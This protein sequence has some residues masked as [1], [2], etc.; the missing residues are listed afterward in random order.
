MKK[1]RVVVKVGNEHFAKYRVN[2]LVKF[3]SF[4]DHTWPTWRWFNVYEHREGENGP[5][6]AN[7]TANNRP[8][9]RFV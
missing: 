7:F 2:D 9:S 5:Q 3:A 4:L 8:T 1:Y 6:I